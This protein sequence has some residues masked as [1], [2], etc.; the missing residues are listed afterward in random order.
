MK[1]YTFLLFI[2]VFIVAACK[3]DKKDPEDSFISALS[4]IKAQ[5]N[6]IDTSLYQITLYNSDDDHTDTTYLKRE[7]LRDVAKSFLDL[8]DITVSN[9]SGQYSQERLIDAEQNILSITSTAKDSLLEIQQQI[10]IVA[11]EDIGSGKV[12]SIFVDRFRDLPDGLLEQK[13]YWEVDKYFRIGN[14]IHHP[15]QP[16]EVSVTRVTWE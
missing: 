12:K 10:I 7:E 4:I 14:I 11:L 13:M 8:P 16:E 3:N 6:H 9:L 1:W 15:D 5:V 2:P